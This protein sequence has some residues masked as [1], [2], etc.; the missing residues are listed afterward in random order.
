MQVFGIAGFKNSGK[1]TLVVDLIKIFVARGIRV[2]TVKH[3]HH[4]FD[5]D[6]PGKDSYQH[7]EAGAAEVVVA[8]DRRWAHIRELRDEAEP[9]LEELLQQITAADL[10]LV[11]GFKHG[12]HKRLEL[13]RAGNES[14]KLA[15]V[16][17]DICAIVSDEEI[18][19]APVIVLD[20]A[21]P[22]RIADFILSE[23][24]L[25]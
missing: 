19:D 25:G 3:A 10:V 22:E 8:S 14:P 21:D 12:A 24:A 4:D 1:T 16:D 15:D 11:E 23:L 2:A 5:V 13:R 9:S 20:R 18:L 6:K 7:R 17:K